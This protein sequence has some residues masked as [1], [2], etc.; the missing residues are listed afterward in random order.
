M[1]HHSLPG[2]ISV[3]KLLPEGFSAHASRKTSRKHSPETF[4]AFQMS[5]RSIKE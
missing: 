4:H 3:N 2:K 5:K 1:E